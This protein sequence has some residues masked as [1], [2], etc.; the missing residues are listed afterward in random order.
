MRKRHLC[1]LTVVLTHPT[2][3]Q[4]FVLI[5]KTKTTTEACTRKH[6][7]RPEGAGRHDQPPVP[8]TTGG[9]QWTGSRCHHECRHLWFR[10]TLFH[11]WSTL[12]RFQRPSLT[13][14]SSW[15]NTIGIWSAQSAPHHFFA[16]DHSADNILE[17]RLACHS[18]S[19]LLHSC[20][21]FSR[22]PWSSPLHRNSTSLGPQPFPRFESSRLH[23]LNHLLYFNYKL[24]L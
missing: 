4:N 1:L 3:T 24:L 20:H 16:V 23:D 5:T 8:N 7:K 18:F 11:K 21:T 6:E 10:C 15:T 9:E 12:V 2:E 14:N 19:R 22:W 13:I 17:Q